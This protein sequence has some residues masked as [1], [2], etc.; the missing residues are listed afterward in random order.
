MKTITA[1]VLALGGT[2]GAYAASDFVDTAQVVSST[3]II[4]RGAEQRQEC[5]TVAAPQRSGS[6]NILGS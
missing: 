2:A 5:D 1:L 4:E 6:N 3:P